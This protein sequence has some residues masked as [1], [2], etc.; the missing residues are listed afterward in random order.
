MKY[1]KTTED[2]V[3]ERAGKSATRVFEILRREKLDIK[4]MKIIA[5]PEDPLKSVY[6]DVRIPL[7]EFEE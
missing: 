2:D 7:Y 5:N 6:L 3:M 4:M 1:L